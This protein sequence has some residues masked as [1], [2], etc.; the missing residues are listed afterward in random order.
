MIEN[1]LYGLDMDDRVGQ[2]NCFGVMSQVRKH[3]RRISDGKTRS[4]PCN[5]IGVVVQLTG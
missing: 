5:K 1:Q 2:R 3:H 4:H